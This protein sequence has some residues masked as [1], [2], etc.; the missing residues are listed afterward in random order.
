MTPKD[1]NVYR[2]FNYQIKVPAGQQLKVWLRYSSIIFLQDEKLT[3]QLNNYLQNA[4]S[5]TA[6]REVFQVYISELENLKGTPKITCNQ[7]AVT[8]SGIAGF[9]EPNEWEYYGV[10]DSPSG[11]PGLCES[12]STGRRRTNSRKRGRGRRSASRIGA[13]LVEVQYEVERRQI[14]KWVKGQGSHL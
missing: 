11:R 13:S 3:Y 8:L 10:F 4:K 5:L 2:K 14:V 9:G 7:Q 6:A 12:S 1:I